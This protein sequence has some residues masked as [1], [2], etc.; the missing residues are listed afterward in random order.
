[1]EVRLYSRRADLAL[2]HLLLVAEP[3]KATQTHV[4]QHS[5]LSVKIEASVLGNL[6]VVS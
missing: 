6:H 2:H 5:W 4:D 3:R 1:M